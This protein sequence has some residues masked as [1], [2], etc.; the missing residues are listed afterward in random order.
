MAKSENGNSSAPGTIVPLLV[1]DRAI[2]IQKSAAVTFS[3]DS[4]EQSRISKSS[5]RANVAA[6]AVTTASLGQI[7]KQFVKQAARAAF[8][9]LRYAVS[10]WPSDVVLACRHWP[11]ASDISGTPRR[12]RAAAAPAREA[13]VFST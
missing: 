6:L 4:S 12:D 8:S 1:V 2:R 5:L 11:F 9:G 10:G 13:R 3:I 7:P